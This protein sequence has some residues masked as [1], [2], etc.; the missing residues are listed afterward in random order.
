MINREAVDPVLFPIMVDE[1]WT[2]NQ[3]FADW[4]R[5]VAPSYE[6]PALAIV[7]SG[8][9]D[10]ALLHQRQESGN[11]TGLNDLSNGRPAFLFLSTG[12]GSAQGMGPISAEAARWMADAAR[13]C[14]DWLFIYK[15]R[16]GRADNPIP[17]EKCFKG[18][19]NVHISR[20][21]RELREFLTW[22]K[23][24]VVGALG[25]NGLYM[26]AGMGK[27]ACRL[28]VSRRQRPNP[29]IDEIAIPVDS[30]D[31]LVSVLARVR[32]RAT[33]SPD[34][35][36]LAD[37][38]RFPYRGHVLDRMTSLALRHLQSGSHASVG[39]VVHSM[40]EAGVA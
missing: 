30:P 37:D 9:V 19:T 23:L 25:S 13:R 3:T 36:P 8:E 31:D 10:D 26:A 18:L 2:W 17:G 6:L 1:V 5:S 38:A 33:T 28:L 34:A 14:P 12:F 24:A 21:D 16:P 11:V 27:L 22:D 32:P 39:H 7:G 40:D 35:A 15:T 29:V 20:G 4:I